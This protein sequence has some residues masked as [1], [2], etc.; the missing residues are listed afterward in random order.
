MADIKAGGKDRAGIAVVITELLEELIQAPGKTLSKKQV[1]THLRRFA[2]YYRDIVEALAH[3]GTINEITGQR[4]GIELR[5]DRDLPP[6]VLS[7]DQWTQL[8]KRLSRLRLDTMD[9]E[10]VTE[11]I[12]RQALE[13]LEGCP[14]GIHYMDLF[15]RLRD[16]LPSNFKSNTIHGTICSLTDREPENVF[17]PSKGVFCL[18]KYRDGPQVVESGTPPIKGGKRVKECDFYRPFAE[19]LVKTLQ[20]CTIAEPVGGNVLKDKWGTP[21]VIGVR[22]QE[23]GAFMP[24]PTEIVSAEI[25]L[26]TNSLIT[27]FGQACAYRL[28]SHKSYIVVPENSPADDIARLDTLSRIFGIGLIT[29][30]PQNAD[31]PKFSI[32]ARA[33][34]HDPDMLYVNNC[35]R[36]L[37][38][39]EIR[40]H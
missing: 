11:T 6:D 1:L 7:N 10:K 34:K 32:R 24:L 18:T 21:D 37:W 23:P 2:A 19:W 14:Q 33:A 40:L 35:M 13:I 22:K 31:D 28:F 20:E 3:T 16:V 27:A 29:F 4:G 36:R 25:K 5:T 39:A 26:D 30:D 9:H 8:L 12:R 38:E 15:N 17:K